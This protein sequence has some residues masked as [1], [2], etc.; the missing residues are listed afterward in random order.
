MANAKCLWIAAALSV[1]EAVRS[2]AATG[3]I[4]Q[5]VALCMDRAGLGNKPSHSCGVWN[6][7]HSHSQAG[8]SERILLGLNCFGDTRTSPLPDNPIPSRGL[9]W[10]HGADQTRQHPRSLS[11]LSL[12]LWCAAPRSGWLGSCASPPQE[13]R[14]TRETEVQTPARPVRSVGNEGWQH[15]KKRLH[16]ERRIQFRPSL[17][18]K[19]RTCPVFK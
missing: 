3:R 1:S 14:E 16:R 7:H 11:Y 4:D 8:R 9:R 12:T 18:L 13:P 5:T 19:S 17:P 6:Q 2:K 10:R 15:Q